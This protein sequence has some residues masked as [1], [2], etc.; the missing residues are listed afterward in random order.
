MY[1]SKYILSVCYMY[2]AKICYRNQLIRFKNGTSYCE[3]ISVITVL[4]YRLSI[5]IRLHYQTTEL[6]LYI[7]TVYTYV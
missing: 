5:E 1:Y 6:T 4:K 7:H 3:I 2:I